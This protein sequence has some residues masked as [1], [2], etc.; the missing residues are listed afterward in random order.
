MRSSTPTRRLLN[1]PRFTRRMAT[2]HRLLA[3]AVSACFATQYA[4]ANP[5][6]EAVVNGTAPT[7]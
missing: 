6:G 7:Q 4:M 2:R 5:A 3:T 1:M